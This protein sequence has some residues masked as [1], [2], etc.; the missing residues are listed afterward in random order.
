M[1]ASLYH[2]PISVHLTALAAAHF[3]VLAFGWL[4]TAESLAA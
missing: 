3:G 1:K 4:V 2:L